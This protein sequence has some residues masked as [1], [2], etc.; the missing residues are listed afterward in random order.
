MNLRID[1]H[2]TRSKSVRQAAIA[3]A[4]TVALLFSAAPSFAA[5]ACASAL[6]SLDT[7]QAFSQGS[8]NKAPASLRLDAL[9][10]PHPLNAVQPEVPANIELTQYE[11]TAQLDSVELDEDG[12]SYRLHLTD[13]KGRQIIAHAVSAECVM[14]S[15]L[16]D[17]TVAGAATAKSAVV[18]FIGAFFAGDVALPA[19][20]TLSGLGSHNVSAASD[21]ETS[22]NLVLDAITS[23][24]FYGDDLM[25]SGVAL[26]SK[27]R[28]FVSI[29]KAK[30][31]AKF[32][33]YLTS[34]SWA[35]NYCLS[36]S[37]DQQECG[38]SNHFALVLHGLWPQLLSGSRL[39]NC[40]SEPPS[41]TAI[42]QFPGLFPS[43]SLYGHEWS[44]H[45]TCSGLS[46]VAYL[47]VA[48]SAKQRIVTPPT[49]VAAT[50]PIST[51]VAAIKQAVLATNTAVPS[52]SLTLS[53][54]GVQLAEVRVCLNASGSNFANCGA[55]VVA[56]EQNSCGSK[57]TVQ[58]VR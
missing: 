55:D 35:P 36:H 32:D 2:S 12:V 1:L 29:Q 40:T 57:V 24:Q 16:D 8:T 50:T 15:G 18:D 3:A 11:M 33:Y 41:S 19:T 27:P 25:A 52:V 28:T 10:E 34:L 13:A 22:H 31:A 17:N 14:N 54:S 46:Q 30:A 44:K 42:A 39:G 26:D 58:N 56:Q 20:V 49:F 38:S 47:T 6:K 37:S 5:G 21:D 7:G 9:N 4:G 51:T 45:G 43:T 53:C 23:I 48:Q